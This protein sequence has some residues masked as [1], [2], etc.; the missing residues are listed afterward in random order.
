MNKNSTA[1][2][3]RSLI[4]F[5]E[6]QIKKIE[7]LPSLKQEEKENAKTILNEVIERYEKEQK[8]VLVWK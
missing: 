7:K 5:E 2:L 3:R 8:E 4:F 1:L 6:I